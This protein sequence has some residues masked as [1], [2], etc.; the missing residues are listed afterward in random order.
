MSICFGYFNNLCL[1]ACNV[2]RDFSLVSMYSNCIVKSN[3]LTIGLQEHYG[4]LVSS[5]SSDTGYAV[6]SDARSKE[7][8]C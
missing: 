2:I 6:I 8:I 4:A 7:E 1:N 5:H 3:G